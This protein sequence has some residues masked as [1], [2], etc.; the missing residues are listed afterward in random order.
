[1]TQCFLEGDESK[2]VSYSGRVKWKPVKEHV[3]EGGFLVES[4]EEKLLSQRSQAS[5]TSSTQRGLMFS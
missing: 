2:V 3:R 1:M 4:G 5:V